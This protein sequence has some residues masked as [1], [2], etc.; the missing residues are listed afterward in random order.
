MRHFWSQIQAFSLFQEVLQLVK[1][2]GAGFKYSGT[3]LKFQP[4]NT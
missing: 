3:I 1:F 2:E 4:K